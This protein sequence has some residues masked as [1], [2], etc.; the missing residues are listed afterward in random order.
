MVVSAL[1]EAPNAA[2]IGRKHQGGRR[3]HALSSLLDL[4]LCVVLETRSFSTHHAAVRTITLT[5][6][7]PS[8]WTLF[9]R[10]GSGPLR[11]P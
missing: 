5:T 2:S 1:R 8:G 6:P 3:S 10:L 7:W 11:S 9:S 4:V